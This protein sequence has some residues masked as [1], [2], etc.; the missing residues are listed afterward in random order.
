[1]VEIRRITGI[2]TSGK[3]EGAMY[4]MMPEYN[5]ILKKHAGFSPY[6][7]TLNIAVGSEDYH[8]VVNNGKHVAGFVKGGVE[9]GG[10][11]IMRARMYGVECAAIVPEKTVHKDCVEIVAPVCLRERFNIKDG[12]VVEVVLYGR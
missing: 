1:M 8:Y 4:V 5:K 7:G 3:G 6:P 9:Y 2:V 11:T 12:D 10:I